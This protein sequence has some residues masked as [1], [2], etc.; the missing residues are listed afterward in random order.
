MRAQ[1]DG[2]W[3]SGLPEAAQIITIGQGFVNDGETVVPTIQNDDAKT[4]DAPA[5]PSVQSVSKAEAPAKG[6]GQIISGD[7]DTAPAGSTQE[8]KQ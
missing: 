4:D 1:T 6:N 5:Q 2:I 8:A 7:A 3:I